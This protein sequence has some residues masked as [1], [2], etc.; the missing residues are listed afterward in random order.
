MHSQQVVFLFERCTYVA[1][2]STAVTCVSVGR[3]ASALGCSMPVM[4][5]ML[6]YFLPASVKVTVKVSSDVHGTLH[7][8]MFL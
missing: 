7:R 2:S 4:V 8:D 5:I 1:F 6:P 3:A